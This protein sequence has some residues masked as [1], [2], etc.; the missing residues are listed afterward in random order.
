MDG[1]EKIDK[2]G[3]EV[4]LFL[5]GKCIIQ[6]NATHLFAH[7]LLLPVTDQYLFTGLQT[8]FTDLMYWIQQHRSLKVFHHASQ[9][10]TCFANSNKAKDK[11]MNSYKR[12]DSIDRRSQQSS[13]KS[14]N[15]TSQ[16]F[17]STAQ[18]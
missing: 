14:Q 3:G 12:T 7:W 8:V 10:L 2:L 15:V 4:I 11:T 16:W 13:E 1:A 5:R 9:D 18:G 6:V 17:C